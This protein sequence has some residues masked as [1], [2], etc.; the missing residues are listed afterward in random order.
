MFFSDALPF[1]SDA[2]PF[3]SD[4]LPFLSFLSLFFSSLLFSSR[5]WRG[6]FGVGWFSSSV[7]SRGARRVSNAALEI[8]LCG[9]GLCGARARAERREVR[10]ELFDGRWTRG[11]ESFRVHAVS[12]EGVRGEVDGSGDGTS[13]VGVVIGS[14]RVGG[15]GGWD[16]GRVFARRR[17]DGARA[18]GRVLRGWRA[19]RRCAAPDAT[20]SV[21]AAPMTNT[22]MPPVAAIT[23]PPVARNTESSSI[24]SGVIS[25]ACRRPSFGLTGAPDAPPVVPLRRRAGVS[26]KPRRSASRAARVVVNIARRVSAATTNDGAAEGNSVMARGRHR[27]SNQRAAR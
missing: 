11:R 21:A 9:V 4:A 13:D 16:V 8:R 27:S 12:C 25:S 20:P 1:L 6:V 14:S 5:A 3:L 18:R 24:C 10:A 23:N 26:P 7:P 22:P 15:R 17:T 19:P 2:L